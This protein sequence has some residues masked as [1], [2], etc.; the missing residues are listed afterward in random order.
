MGKPPEFVRALDTPPYSLVDVS[1]KPNLGF[2]CPMLTLGGLAVDEST[3]RVRGEDG[4]PIGGLYAAGRSAVGI[5]SRSYVSGLSLA[6]CV[7]S[8]RRAGVNSALAHGVLDKN[9]NVF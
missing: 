7:F 8:G 2:P 9:E 5:C 4:K 6:D 3:G 1:I